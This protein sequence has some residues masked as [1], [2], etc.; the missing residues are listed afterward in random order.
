MKH[1]QRHEKCELWYVTGQKESECVYF[2]GEPHGN[3]KQW[4]R[5][6]QLIF[7]IDYVMGYPKKYLLIILRT[8]RKAKYIRLA[9]MTKTKVFNEWWYHPDNPGGKLAKK[10]LSEI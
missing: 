1:G 3:W 10:K 8:L 2:E 6:G 7:S 9:K 5:Q 4:D